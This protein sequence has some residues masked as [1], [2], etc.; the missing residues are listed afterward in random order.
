MGKKVIPGRRKKY[1]LLFMTLP[2]MIIVLLFNYVPIFGW[3]Y[4]VFDYI[5]GVSVFDCDFVGLDYFRLIFKDANVVRTLKN[6]FIFAV[7]G[8]VLTPLPMFFAILLNEI[9]CGPVRRAVS[10]TH[11]DV[12]KRQV[13]DSSR[14][15]GMG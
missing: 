4:S 14:L 1:N 2:F 5:P 15:H 7:I 6:T 13:C 9:K 11:L 10:Y 3:I 12:Y 8:I